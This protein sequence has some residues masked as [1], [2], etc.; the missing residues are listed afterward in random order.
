[1]G[2]AGGEVPRSA[3]WLK[4]NCTVRGGREEGCDIVGG[5]GGLEGSGGAGCQKR[6][7]RSYD[8]VKYGKW[9]V[10]MIR[11]VETVVSSERTAA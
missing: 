8:L 2:W 11:W 1:M 9:M 6:C 10:W 4:Q 7:A 3:V 5:V